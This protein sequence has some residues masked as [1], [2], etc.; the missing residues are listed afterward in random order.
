M[1]RPIEELLAEDLADLSPGE[2]LQVYRHNQKLEAK[3]GQTRTNMAPV[4]ELYEIFKYYPKAQKSPNQL[5]KH[6][7]AE[8]TSLSN[9]RSR[10]LFNT[11]TKRYEDE[12]S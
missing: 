3:A 1:Y 8:G 7:R 2:F 5:V 10:E 9:E 6:V 4:D 12:Q 11:F